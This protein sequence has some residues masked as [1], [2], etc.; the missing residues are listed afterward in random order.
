MRSVLFIALLTLALAGHDEVVDDVVCM[1]CPETA[2]CTNGSIFSCPENSLSDPSQFPSNVDD[3]VCLAGFFR[4]GDVCEVGQPPHY[5]IDGVRLV[6]NT[7]MVTTSVL[8]SSSSDCVCDVGHGYADGLCTQCEVGKIKNSTGNEPCTDCAPGQCV[9]CPPGTSKIEVHGLVT[10]TSCP[11][12]SVSAS[13]SLHADDCVCLPGWQRIG[14]YCE[15]CVEGTIKSWLGDSACTPCAADTYEPN[16]GSVRKECTPCGEFSSTHGQYGSAACQCVAGYEDIEAGLENFTSCTECQ[17]GTFRSDVTTLA[18]Q[19]CRACS[20]ENERLDVICSAS[21]DTTCR[22][23]QAHSN[24]AAYDEDATL[25]SCNAGY[26]LDGAQCV[27]CEAGTYKSSDSNNSVGCQTCESGKNAVE[28]GASTC[29]ACTS[30]CPADFFVSQDC[31]PTTDINCAACRSCGP[32]TYS[33]SV[34]GS[35]QDMT[36]G[37]AFNDGRSDTVCRECEPGFYCY[38]SVRYPCGVNSSSPTGSNSSEAC[39]CADGFFEEDGVCKVCTQDHFCVGNSIYSCPPLSHN[40]YLGASVVTDCQCLHFFYHADVTADNFT[41]HACEPTDPCY[42]VTFYDCPS[43]YHMLQPVSSSESECICIDGY[44]GSDGISCHP[45]PADHFCYDGQIFGCGAERWTDNLEYQQDVSDCVCRPGTFEDGGVC[46][47]CSPN[48]FCPGDG[49]Q[50]PCPSYSNSSMSASGLHECICG[51]GYE[52][53]SYPSLTC[54]QCQT[55]YFKDSAGNRACSV[56]KACSAELDQEYEKVSCTYSHD[57][58]CDACDVC[59]NNVTY[60][61]APCSDK[62]NTVCSPCSTCSYDVEWRQHD[63]IVTRDTICQDITFALECPHGQYRGGHTKTSDSFCSSCTYRDTKFLGLTLHD[64]KSYGLVYNDPHSCRIECLGFSVLRDAHDHSLGCVSCESGNALLKSFAV[65]RDANDDQVSCSFTCKADYERITRSDGT[66][67]CVVPALSQ[68]GDDAVAHVVEVTNVER[69][70]D[71][72]LFTVSHSNHSRF[73]ITV[74][75]SAP[76]N[77]ETI[78]G[79]CYAHTWRVSTLPQAGFSNSVTDDGC[80]QVLPSVKV[81]EST[82][83]FEISDALLPTIAVCSPS[84]DAV[85]ECV[86]TISL[87]DTI[88]WSVKFQAIA[89]HIQR[90]IQH[91]AF[92]GLN[93]YIPLKDFSVDILKAYPADNGGFVYLITTRIRGYDLTAVMRVTGMTQVALGNVRECARLSFSN[94]SIMLNESVIQ[95]SEEDAEYVTYWRGL[96]EYISVYYTLFT[97]NASNQDIVVIRNLTRATPYCT[98]SRHSARFF[99]ARVMSVSGLGADAI[100]GMHTVLHPTQV[101]YGEVGTLTTFIAQANNERPSTISVQN[102]IAVYTKS[103]AAQAAVEAYANATVVTQGNLD[104]TYGFRQLCRAQ[105]GDCA[106]E[107]ILTGIHQHIHFLKD[108]SEGAKLLARAWILQAYGTSHDGG[109]IDAMCARVQKYPLR[110]FL[111]VLV[112]TQHSLP[113]T[114]WLDYMRASMPTVQARLW[115]NFKMTT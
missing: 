30:Y 9:D 32:G 108:C 18:C 90:A 82:L 1:T 15:P 28:S 40:Y 47:A 5:Y 110:A 25:C 22:P 7:S 91:T 26:G 80:S 39:V 35:E 58:V 52:N 41:C 59:E 83:K 84:S 11:V 89:F 27:P 76:E 96:S 104:F 112:H 20:G 73:I 56:C 19:I 79:C 107:Y 13:F 29:D 102:L 62:E 69:V 75:R 6:C 4:N 67:D 51:I 42:D 63:C 17:D 87:I 50:H 93:Q 57:A 65:N 45:C 95:V 77:C 94:A 43:S 111:G 88:V 14:T 31:T 85:E 23:C 54:S 114:S 46:V 53:L 60:K 48:F 16:V 78:R 10:C 64:A 12:N 71:A 61:S 37:L 99:P 36:C 100:Y 113:R 68:R 109:H 21:T 8:A 103:A 38:G 24:R 115:I 3:C 105:L 92:V 66:D 97:S 33:R 101:T 2:Y 74:G 49:L 81:D 34:D 55:S 72:S 44:H 70:S 86:F 98:P 106:Y